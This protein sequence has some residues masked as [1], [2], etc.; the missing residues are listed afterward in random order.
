M[1]LY[2]LTSDDIKHYKYMIEHGY[3]SIKLKS[4]TQSYIAFELMD[5]SG[6]YIAWPTVTGDLDAFDEVLDTIF[7]HDMNIQSVL[8]LPD[9]I[10]LLLFPRYS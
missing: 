8:E 7:E 5:Q 4:K 9:K 10:K 3:E 2:Y 1:D 6:V